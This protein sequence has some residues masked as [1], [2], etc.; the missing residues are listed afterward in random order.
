M[1]RVMSS[2]WAEMLRG[3]LR[4]PAFEPGGPPHNPANVVV[5]TPRSS[6]P[7]HN[8]CNVAARLRRSWPGQETD[9]LSVVALTECARVEP[10]GKT[11]HIGTRAS[12]ASTSGAEH[13]GRGIRVQALISGWM[14]VDGDL[15]MPVAG[16]ILP[17]LALRLNE[18]PID[19]DQ[20]SL[21]IEGILTWARLTPD[22]LRSVPNPRSRRGDGALETVIQTSGFRVLTMDACLPDDPVP[23][24]GAHVVREGYLQSVGAHEFLDFDLPDI[25]QSWSVLSVR[26]CREPDDLLVELEPAR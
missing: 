26:E 20:E 18:K 23:E 2:R 7:G 1:V 15:P 11:D 14:L 22:A 9:S 13:E 6:H 19:R 3:L 5:R 12:P 24:V 4:S 10:A 17:G 21:A 8:P 16:E 25:S